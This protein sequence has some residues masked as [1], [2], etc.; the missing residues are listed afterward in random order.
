MGAWKSHYPSGNPRAQGS[1]TDG[2]ERGPWVVYEA[3][4]KASQTWEMDLTSANYYDNKRWLRD[5]EPDEYDD[6]R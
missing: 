6:I 4:S 3:D 5:I 2:D 1:Y